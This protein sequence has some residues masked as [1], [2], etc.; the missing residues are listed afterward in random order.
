MHTLPYR[1]TKPQ[2]SARSEDFSITAPVTIP[3]DAYDAKLLT[4]FWAACPEAA[5]LRR[6]LPDLSDRV[7]L[8]HRGV[9]LARQSGMLITEKVGAAGLAFATRVIVDQQTDVCHFKLKLR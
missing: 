9:G 2:E 4:A 3:W 7:L 8:M 6:R 5:A 1:H